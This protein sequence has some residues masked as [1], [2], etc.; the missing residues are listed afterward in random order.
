M[1]YGLMRIAEHIPATAMDAGLRSFVDYVAGPAKSCMSSFDGGQL[2]Y[3]FLLGARKT[4]MWSA[5]LGA[6]EGVLRSLEPK[7]DML[8]QAAA[9]RANLNGRPYDGSAAAFA[10]QVCRW[11]GEPDTVVWCLHDEAPIKPWSVDVKP[12]TEMVERETQSRVLDLKPGEI[13]PIFEN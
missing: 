9:G 3:N 8:I 1:K 6:Y 10:T 13:T 2:A 4:L 12:A 11:L 5:H 7:P